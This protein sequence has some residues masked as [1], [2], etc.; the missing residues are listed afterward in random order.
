MRL[1]RCVDWALTSD[2]W[3][4]GSDPLLG[5]KLADLDLA[6]EPSLGVT[7]A[8]KVLTWDVTWVYLALT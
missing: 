7:S 1:V 2:G 5:V 8:L 4:A 3:L 6:L